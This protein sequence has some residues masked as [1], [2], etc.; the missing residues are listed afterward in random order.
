[1]K[2]RLERGRTLLRARLA[3]RGVALSGSIIGLLLARNAAPA[4]PPTLVN[5]TAVAAAKF[6]LGN[7]PAPFMS[8]SVVVLA[9]EVLNTMFVTRVKFAVL[10]VLFVGVALFGAGVG[11]Y[12]A[13]ARPQEK[14]GPA[15]VNQKQRQPDVQPKK[16]T[17]PP[18]AKEA[19]KLIRVLLFAD[20]P[21][22]EY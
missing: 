6:A 14:D 13:L 4:V 12:R 11:S 7:L 2:I 19:K 16:L 8:N 1:V 22:R 9:R 18:P 15:P 10:L 17:Q 3:R 5:E 20:A 21:S